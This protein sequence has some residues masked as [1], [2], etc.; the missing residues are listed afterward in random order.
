MKLPYQFFIARRYFKSKKKNRGL[1]INTLISI[2]GV[3][4]GVMTLLTVL[5][6][7]SGFHEDIRGKIL[8]VNPHIMVQ[9]FDGKIKDHNS[10]IKEINDVEGVTASSPF[11]LGQVML[12]YRDRAQ[13][14][15]IKGIDSEAKASTSE[16]SKYMKSG[17]IADLQGDSGM[18]GIIVGKE[19]LRNLGLLVGDEIP[20]ISPMGDIGPLGMIPKMKK[21]RVVGFFEV[22]MFEFDSGLVL[23]H[24]KD[25]QK[26]FGYGDSVYGIEI[27]V[28][29]PDKASEIAD[30]INDKLRLPYNARDWMEM[31]RNLFSALELEKWVMFIILTLIILVASF[32]IVSNLIMIV[33]EKAREIAI[34]KAMGA[35]SRGIMSIFLVHGL[36]I[37]IAGTVIGMGGGLIL[38]WLLNVYEFP[39]APDVYYLSHLP[40]RLNL[41]DFIV[42]PLAAIIITLLATIYPSWQA[43]K[44]DPVEPLRYE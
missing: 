42:V 16:V 40:V 6:V 36:I 44:L 2:G 35:T 27:R 30:M 21:F 34:L 20:V 38:C 32:N 14:V 28:S 29:D 17:S 43:S 13:G 18:P 23:I 1:S 24:M 8:G 19:L 31:N 25:A 11:I 7:M 37:G 4:L 22:G 3:A 10:L 26:F 41:F 39:L 15:V 5:S 33:M 9:S 12:R